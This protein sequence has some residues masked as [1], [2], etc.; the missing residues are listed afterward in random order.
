[1]LVVSTPINLIILKICVVIH[2]STHPS[3]FYHY[4][5]KGVGALPNFSQAGYVKQFVFFLIVV[6]FTCIWLVSFKGS[7]TFMRWKPIW[8]W[9]ASPHMLH[10]IHIKDSSSSRFNCYTMYVCV[11]A[12]A[13]VHTRVCVWI[14]AQPSHDIVV[15][16]GGYVD[17]VT[18]ST[19]LS[20]RLYTP[21]YVGS[22]ASPCL[23]FPL[24]LLLCFNT[25]ESHQRKGK[26]ILMF[27]IY[28]FQIYITF[29]DRIQIQKQ[30]RYKVI[31]EPIQ[32]IRGLIVKGPCICKLVQSRDT[33][34][35]LK[36]YFTN[37]Y[38]NRL[39]CFTLF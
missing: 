32:N 19:S 8:Q 10:V 28:I 33:L 7:S 35:Y 30:N 34:H 27:Y 16:I 17:E 11:R 14:G 5:P 6:G 24:Y 15:K 2:P 21:R 9:I 3:M 26:Y 23:L 31:A 13:R 4:Y 38:Q 1:M 29:K 39:V 36:L 25:S 37:V 18:V 12:R 22:V 20:F